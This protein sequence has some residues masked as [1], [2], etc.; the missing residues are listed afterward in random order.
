MLTLDSYYVNNDYSEPIEESD[1]PTVLSL[2]KVDRRIIADQPRVTH[3]SIPWDSE[4][5]MPDP[6]ELG[7]DIGDSEVVSFEGMSEEGEGES[8]EDDSDSLSEDMESED[9]MNVEK[10]NMTFVFSC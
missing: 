10:G 6:R 8:E 2:E 4:S 7:E 9:G 3:F 1:K 5:V